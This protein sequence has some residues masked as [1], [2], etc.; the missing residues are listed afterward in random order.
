LRKEKGTDG[1]EE[2]RK[3]QRWTEKGKKR[4]RRTNVRSFI[5]KWLERDRETE[6]EMG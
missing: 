1:V 6:K 2:K 3:I 4:R 5:L